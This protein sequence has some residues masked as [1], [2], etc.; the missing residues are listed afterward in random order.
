MIR[1]TL[2]GLYG[3]ATRRRLCLRLPG[4]QPVSRAPPRLGAVS[5]GSGSR[6]PAIGP[7]AQPKALPG[8]SPPR[9][10]GHRLRDM[11]RGEFETSKGGYAT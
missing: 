2:G 9:L 5:V 4:S 11:V 10:R 1:P 3:R 6:G 8:R 7:W